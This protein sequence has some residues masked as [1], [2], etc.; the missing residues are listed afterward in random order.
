[1]PTDLFM[2][3]YAVSR[4][5]NYFVIGQYLGYIIHVLFALTHHIPVQQY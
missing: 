2:E 4:I 1:M 3:Q 5:T